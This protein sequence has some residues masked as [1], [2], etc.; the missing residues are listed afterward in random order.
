[1]TFSET[2]VQRDTVGRF[3]EKVGTAPELTLASPTVHWTDAEAQQLVALP[4]DEH[5]A[6]D[7][8]RYF[9]IWVD[10]AD[11]R[12]SLGKIA[13][14]QIAEDWQHPRLPGPRHGAAGQLAAGLPW[15]PAAREILLSG[16]STSHRLRL[17][18]VMP[19]RLIEKRL[20]DAYRA[21]EIGSASD[22]LAHLRAAHVGPRFAVI[23]KEEDDL[24]TSAGYRDKLPAD[25][26]PLGRY[27]CLPRSI[28][29]FASPMEDER[30][31]PLFRAK[32]KRWTNT[33][34]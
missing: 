5:D 11:R 8:F 7:L 33:Q 20:F 15:S 27:D 13:R 10:R 1:M 31:L 25:G 21:G 16:E 14:H 12:G 17:E 28:D 32:H 4:D 2:N 26:N 29:E 24:I 18:H 3:S 19:Q 23:T 9:A 6:N 34:R 30:Y 22:M